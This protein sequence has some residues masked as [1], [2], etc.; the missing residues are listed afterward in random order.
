MDYQRTI[1]RIHKA[2]IKDLKDDKISINKFSKITK[3]L[4]EVSTIIKND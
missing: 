3:L 1:L 2:L 4:N